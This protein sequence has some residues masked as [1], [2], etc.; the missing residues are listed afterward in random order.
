MVDPTDLAEG[1]ASVLDAAGVGTYRED[2][3]AYLSDEIAVTLKELPPNPDQ[4][5]AITVYHEEDSPN[6]RD[7]REAK[8]VQ[9]R[10]RGTADDVA[11]VDDVAQAAFVALHG[12]HHTMFGLVPIARCVRLYIAPL[13]AD[14]NGRHE[15]TDNYRI[16]L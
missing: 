12:Q 13:G 1:V 8:N 7:P 9:L 14:E 3:S 6:S 15:R 5:I 11:S 10:F 2:G 4:A 16:V